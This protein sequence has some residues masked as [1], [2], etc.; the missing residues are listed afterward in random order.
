M[1]VCLCFKMNDREILD[2][3]NEQ[4][5]ESIIDRSKKSGCGSCIQA[6]IDLKTLDEQRGARIGLRKPGS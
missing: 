1:W 2:K 4:G 6:I 5:L 3:I